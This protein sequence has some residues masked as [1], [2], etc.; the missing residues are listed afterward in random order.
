MEDFTPLA[1]EIAEGSRQVQ[2]SY[3]CLLSRKRQANA[4]T[5]NPGDM[6]RLSLAIPYSGRSVVYRSSLAQKTAAPK[7]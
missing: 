1:E 4:K 3:C 2:R 6:A 7:D 5:R